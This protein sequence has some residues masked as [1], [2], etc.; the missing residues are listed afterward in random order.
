MDSK[1]SRGSVRAYAVV[2]LDTFLGPDA[3][4]QDVVTVKEVLPTLDAAEREVRRLNELAK[5]GG[6]TYCSQPTRWFR[7]GRNRVNRS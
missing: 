6:V 5:D 7:E 1:G 2:R 3:S 4:I